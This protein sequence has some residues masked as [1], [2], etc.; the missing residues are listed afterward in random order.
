M[1]PLSH[2]RTLPLSL[3]LSLHL[4]SPFEDEKRDFFRV[5]VV[6]AAHKVFDGGKGGRREAGRRRGESNESESE[7]CK[8]G[9][10][11]FSFGVNRSG[12]DEL[13]SRN[14]QEHLAWNFPFEM[15][16]EL[17]DIAMVDEVQ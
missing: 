7:S 8:V 15:L 11:E 1:E 5:V 6:V 17:F 10:F 9:S 3:S 14:G 13:V 4:F 12:D 2:L 16:L